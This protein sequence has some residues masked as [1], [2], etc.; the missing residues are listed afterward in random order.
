MK[1]LQER[2]D[3]MNPYFRGVEV[4]NN[5]LIVKVV[6]PSNWKY[7]NSE[8]DRIKA[9]PSEDESGLVFYYADSSNTTYDDLFDLIE[10][11]IRTN[12]EITLKLTLLK[13]KVE[14]LREIF[15]SHPYEELEMLEF[16]FAKKEKPKKRGP[17]PK[18][19]KKEEPEPAKPEE[20]AN[21]EKG[22]T[23]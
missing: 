16:T 6:F 20:A 17:K 9:V 19:K 21:E 7:F 13:Q 12:N 11:T 4:Y 5:A 3:G 10:E 1:T 22:D 15:S 23:E 8:D 18:V 2:M 14:E